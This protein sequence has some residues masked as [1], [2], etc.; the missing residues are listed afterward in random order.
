MPD[1]SACNGFRVQLLSETG[2]KQ[3]GEALDEVPPCQLRIC[4][5]VPN[6]EGRFSSVH[7]KNASLTSKW[8]LQLMLQCNNAGCLEC[9]HDVITVIAVQLI[10][11]SLDI[12]SNEE[13]NILISIVFSG[14]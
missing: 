4:A 10:L 5:A 1:A 8:S 7:H 9:C 2:S 13:V 11:P 3:V 6:R 12:V 14:L